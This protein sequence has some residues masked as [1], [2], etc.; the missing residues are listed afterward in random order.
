L[1]T[2]DIRKDATKAAIK[3]AIEIVRRVLVL[4]FGA[5]AGWYEP[6]V[7]QNQ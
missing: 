7:N 6:D 3:S 5:I 2:Y 1:D 4:F